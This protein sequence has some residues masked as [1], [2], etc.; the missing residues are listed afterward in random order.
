MHA[1]AHQSSQL[2]PQIAATLSCV[3]G[4]LSSTFPTLELET[5]SDKEETKP[6][7]QDNP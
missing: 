4:E 6:D 5:N 3:P 7:C 1:L 2:D